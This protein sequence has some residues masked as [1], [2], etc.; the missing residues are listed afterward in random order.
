LPSSEQRAG[1]AVGE[2]LPSVQVESG[3][4]LVSVEA[5]TSNGIE[6]GC[7]TL[8]LLVPQQQQQEEQE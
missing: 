4:G 7:C 5:G 2:G 3:Q 1:L 6:V 8:P